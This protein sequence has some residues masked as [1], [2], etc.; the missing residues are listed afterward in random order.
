M[1]TRPF[2]PPSCGPGNE[3][4][5]TGSDKFVI[6]A[7][8]AE[9]LLHSG[10][11]RSYMWS[12]TLDMMHF[13]FLYLCLSLPPLSTAPPT[14]PS[15]LTTNPLQLPC[16][17]HTLLS[18]TTFTPPTLQPPLLTPLP[19]HASPNT[20]FTPHNPFNLHC[21]LPQLLPH[22]LHSSPLTH[23]LPLLLPHHLH[24]TLPSSKS[25]PHSSTHSSPPSITLPLS[26]YP[27]LTST[28][29]DVSP[30]SN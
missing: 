27:F 2:F 22:H 26:A 13:T 7:S 23:Q 8:P 24:S 21:S 4:T 18:H 29:L 14:P 25:T 10:R 3:A 12:I 17:L 28:H 6:I 11:I 9:T 20:T 30:L 5:A 1:E 15:L 16:S 19:L